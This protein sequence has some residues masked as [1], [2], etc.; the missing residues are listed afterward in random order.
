MDITNNILAEFIKIK[1]RRVAI[2]A[3]RVELVAF[4]SNNLTNLII[5]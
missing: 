5:I 4:F 1:Y 3:N 2:Q